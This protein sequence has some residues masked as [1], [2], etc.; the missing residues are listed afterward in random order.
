MAEPSETQTKPYSR[1]ELDRLCF[2]IF[3]RLYDELHQRYKNWIIAIE[4]ANGEYF[5]GLDDFEVLSRACKKCPRT[6]FFVYRLA[7][8]PCADTLC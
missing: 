8:D 6:Q 5:I 4:P 2:P 3:E 7:E 1:E